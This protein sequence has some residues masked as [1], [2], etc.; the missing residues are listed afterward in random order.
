MVVVILIVLRLNVQQILTD[1]DAPLVHICDQLKSLFLWTWRTFDAW[2][3]HAID[4]CISTMSLHQLK[5]HTNQNWD[6]YPHGAMTSRETLCRYC[7]QIN[8]R[9]EKEIKSYLQKRLDQITFIFRCHHSETVG[10]A[11]AC[12]RGAWRGLRL[13]REG[14][15]SDLKQVM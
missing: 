15:D 5:L 14:D 1:L 2:V 9:G 6:Y 10:I 3:R 13:L 7:L 8:Q 4:G 12:R 11:G